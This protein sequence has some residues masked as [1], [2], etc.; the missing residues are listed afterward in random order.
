MPKKHKTRQMT[1]LR[2]QFVRHLLAA[3]ADAGLDQSKLARLVD[4]KPGTVGDY[5]SG[6]SSPGMENLVLVADA[7]GQS[8]SWLVGDKLHGTDT[9]ERHQKDL[10]IR[11]G[12][13]R[14]RALGAVPD[15]ELLAQL[16]ELIQRHPITAETSKV[17]TIKRRVRKSR[18]N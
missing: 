10:A 17:S 5:C 9:L 8:V 14:L 4:L 15:D 11:V 3:I 2:A 16:D 18:R 12:G 7:L 13:E 6:R 1:D